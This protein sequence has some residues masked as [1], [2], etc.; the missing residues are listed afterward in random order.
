MDFILTR[1][2]AVAGA[3]AGLIS[4][5]VMVWADKS[6]SLD[7]INMI[8]LAVVPILVGLGVYAAPRNQQS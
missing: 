3:A 1:I 2:K 4:V 8:W 7:E 5:G 6:I